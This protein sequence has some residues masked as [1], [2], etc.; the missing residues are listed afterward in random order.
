G[1]RYYLFSYPDG[2]PRMI[3]NDLNAYHDLSLTADSSNLVGV[4]YQ[5]NVNIWAVPGGD[6]AKLKQLT[7]S[8]SIGK[9]EGSLG[10][11]WTPDG[12][13]VFTS[14]SDSRSIWVMNGDGSAWKQLTPKSTL[15]NSYPAVSPDGR[16]FAFLRYSDRTYLYR[17]GIDGD[18]ATHLAEVTNQPPQAMIFTQPPLSQ[19]AFSPDGRWVIYVSFGLGKDGIWKIPVEG[20]DP[21]Q[22]SSKQA[23]QPVVS[24]DGKLIAS[25]LRDNQGALKLEIISF[26]GGSPVKVL[27][28]PFAVGSTPEIGLRQVIR[29]LPDS[30]AIAYMDVKNG[31]SNI[32]AQS[33]DGTPPKQ[34]TNF[35]SDEIFWFDLS[36]DGKP[37]LFARGHI[38]KDVVM[39]SNFR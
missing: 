26:D 3:T 12:R 15:E 29:W 36:R 25:F 21:V 14:D 28:V 4:S 35:T 6:V 37:S 32:W 27:D 1:T 9:M 38:S 34:L 10:V 30:R 16:Y 23:Y 19:P 5:G 33:I 13:I 18:Q 24:P 20:G 7:N 8:G 22:V 31:V 11:Q 17:M 39:I 2:Q